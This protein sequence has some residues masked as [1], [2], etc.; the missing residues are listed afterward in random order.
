MKRKQRRVRKKKN[1]KAEERHKEKLSKNEKK[2]REKA[3]NEWEI[4][5]RKTG[6]N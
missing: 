1:S 5:C 2:R 4:V 3:Q 6:K